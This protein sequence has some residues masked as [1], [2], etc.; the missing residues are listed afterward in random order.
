MNSI[1]SKSNNYAA[2]NGKAIGGVVLMPE[3]E[4]FV[5]YV[6]WEWIDQADNNF[7][8]IIKKNVSIAELS[9]DWINK[10]ADYGEDVTHSA[11]ARA[12]FPK[13]F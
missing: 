12:L 13:L 4:G 7:F 3:N 9:T 1:K 11:S 5:G 10:I 2:V 8:A 6:A